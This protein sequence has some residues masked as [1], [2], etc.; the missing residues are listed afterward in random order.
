MG[1]F[2]KLGKKKPEETEQ[3]EVVVAKTPEELKKER[4]SSFVMGVEY[5]MQTENPDEIVVIGK[6]DGRAVS[7]NTVSVCNPGLDNDIAGE[8]QII[9]IRTVDGDA[10]EV[11]GGSA[12]LRIRKNEARDFRVGDV[13]FTNDVPSESTIH[14]Y[15]KALTDTY[16]IKRQLDITEEEAESFSICDMQE[17]IRFYCFLQDQLQ[18]GE[19]TGVNI[20]EERVGK[21]KQILANRILAADHIYCIFSKKTGEPFLFSRTTA[22]Q[23]GGFHV[24]APTIRIF[25]DNYKTRMLGAFDASRY[26]MKRIDNGSKMKGIYN[27]FGLAFYLNGA[28]GVEVITD[29]TILESSL[30]VEKPDE[31]SITENGIPI[32]N[33]GLMR[34]LYMLGQMDQEDIGTP[35][36]KIIYTLYYKFMANE[37]TK[38]KFLVPIHAQGEMPKADEEGVLQ[39]ENGDRFD[40]PAVP[41]KNGR[42]A[43]FVFTDWRHLYGTINEKCEAVVET[44][45]SL[46]NSFD[47]IINSGDYS[48]GGGYISL[49]TY[50]EMEEIAAKMDKAAL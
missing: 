21:L 1:L 25:T 31:A 34:W 28:E 18:N 14:A 30:L 37:A 22:D 49:S 16:V 36:G 15:A 4:A 46:I 42:K 23:N 26:E 5:I 24:S 3:E 20:P 48:K 11:S 32:S 50:N 29:D 33:P 13:L 45:D 9:S 19:S 47:C 39:V 40:I 2:D 17:M 7:G 12:E 35:D 43:I 8:V 44:L 27:F 6:L 41:G 38:A 10:K